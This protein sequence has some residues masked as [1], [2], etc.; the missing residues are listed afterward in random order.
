VLGTSARART[1][2][3]GWR[4]EIMSTTA[5]IVEVL[6]IGFFTAIWLFLLCIRLSFFDF[7]SIKNI[8]AQIGNW[9]T[10]T[11]FIAAAIFYQLGLMMNTLS[12]YI[13]EKFA[14]KEIRNQII[15]GKDYR[16][17]TCIIRT[18]LFVNVYNLCAAVAYIVWSILQKDEIRI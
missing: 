2:Y 12:Y 6:I 7:Y 18:H 16:W 17:D 9:S 8:A 11:L 3:R 14:K 4:I 15:A 5:I 10:L 13:T 1:S